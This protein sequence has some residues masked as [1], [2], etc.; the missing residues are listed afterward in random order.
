M[1][2]GDAEFNAKALAV[3]VMMGVPFLMYAIGGPKLLDY[4][5]LSHL[6]K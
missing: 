3:C 2:T 4:F 5:G 6:N 1:L